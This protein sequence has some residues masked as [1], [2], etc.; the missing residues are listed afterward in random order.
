MTE[1][2]YLLNIDR[3]LHSEKEDS[4]SE[5]QFLLDEFYIIKPVRLSWYVSKARNVWKASG[6]IE[7]AMNLLEDKSWYLFLYP[8]LKELY[9]LYIDLVSSYQDISDMQRHKLFFMGICD[10]VTE[11]D[12]IWENEMTSHFKQVKSDFLQNP[13][14]EDIANQLLEY[15]YIFHNNVLFFI[16]NEYMTRN[17]IPVYTNREWFLKFPNSGFLTENLAEYTKT[18][19]IIFEAEN[20]DGLDERITI[21]LLTKLNKKL[22]L[23]KLPLIFPVDNKV[24]IKDTVDTSI[25]NM[26]SLNNLNTIYPVQ[27][28]F[29]GEILGDNR[30]YILAHLIQNELKKQFAVVLTSGHLMDNLCCQPI[31]KKHLERLYNLVGPSLE[32]HMAFGWA[33]DYLAYISQIHNLDA[34]KLLDTS[35]EVR[36]SIVVPARNSA[37]TLRYTLMTCMNQCYK[38]DYE[39][40]LSDNSTPGNTEVYQLYKE[41]N[42]PRI[43]YYRTPREYNLSR[44][45]E[46]AILHTKGEFLLPLGSDDALLPWALQVLDDLRKTYPDEDVIQWERGFYAWPGFNG[47][48][49]N[50]FVI[51]K[52]YKKGE[53]Q[54]EY[55]SRQFYFNALFNSSSQMY[56]LPN[57]YLNSGCRRRYLK[58]ILEKTGRLFDGICQDLYIGIVNAAIN[59]R[60]LNIHYPLVIAGMSNGSIGAKA[61][62][63]HTLNK[64]E[65]AF[66]NEMKKMANIGG[67]CASPYERLMPEVTTDKSSLY[68]SILRMIA[69]GVIAESDLEHFDFR[70]WF[71]D[72]FHQIDI[73]DPLFDKKIHYFRYTASLHGEEF[74]KWF[75]ENIYHDALTPRLVD[76]EKLARLHEKKCYKEGKNAFGGRTLDASKYNVQ[77]VY[78][79]AKLFEKLTK[80]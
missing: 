10:N 33:G 40:V 54:P 17:K 43:K 78:D 49:Q 15:Y 74:L 69:R 79:A 14:S 16:L 26:V 56:I 4:F 23:I 50:Q 24:Y 65:T 60:I 76:E 8:G 39:I 28:I 63:L 57:L 66:L 48:Q 3:L 1:Q 20:S 46:F 64:E 73:R 77:N 41:L 75:D 55:L 29:D 22:F 42:D 68:N 19:F 45:F 59:D 72:V 80:L 21:Y 18:P 37:Y 47:G 38:G 70:K 53:F 58:T 36:Y 27:I 61:N 6:S 12:T 34:D 30:E 13:E 44:S 5:I 51:P 52:S 9:E 32:N 25:E 35:P 11:D 2:E 7:Q 67:Y 31:L 71:L 62:Q